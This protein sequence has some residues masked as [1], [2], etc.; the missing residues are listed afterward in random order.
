M[1]QTLTLIVF[2]WPFIA[3]SLIIT[4]AGIMENYAWLVFLGAILIIPFSY[5]LN[6]VPPFGGIALFI[7]VLHIASAGAVFEEYPVLAWIL[8]APTISILIFLTIIG[9][10]TDLF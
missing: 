9:T 3:L 2:G 10:I 4:I 6:S 7:P 1:N 8:F 5:N